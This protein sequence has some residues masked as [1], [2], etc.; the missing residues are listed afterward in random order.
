MTA[1]EPARFAFVC[2]RGMNRTIAV[3]DV[4]LATGGAAA[5]RRGGI[6]KGGDD[7]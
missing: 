6:G 7:E 1:S 5:A 2:D 4:E 3:C